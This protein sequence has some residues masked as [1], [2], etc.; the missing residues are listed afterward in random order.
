MSQFMIFTF[1]R[2]G[3]IV[4]PYAVQ[5]TLAILNACELGLQDLLHKPASQNLQPPYGGTLVLPVAE[6]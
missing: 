6:L 3:L 2:R 4:H 1:N 5:I